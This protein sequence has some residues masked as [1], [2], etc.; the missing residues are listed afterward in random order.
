MGY[1]FFILLTFF[2]LNKLLFYSI[3]RES[4]SLN[5]LSDFLPLLK[6]MFYY[7][8]VFVFSF[9]TLYVAQLLIVEK[10]PAKK[11][12]VLIIRS[13]FIAAAFVYSL[14]HFV[15][16]VFYKYNFELPSNRTVTIMWNNRHF[17]AQYS[18]MY[19][20]YFLL[21]V[22]LV[23]GISYLLFKKRQ[24]VQISAHAPAAAI[25]ALVLGIMA[26]ACLY[27]SKGNG[28]LTPNSSFRFVDS[29]YR[30]LVVNPVFNLAYSYAKGVQP[31]DLFI[32]LLE[33]TVP[34]TETDANCTNTPRPDQFFG[35]YRG[36]NVMIIV[37]ESASAENFD[38][39]SPSKFEMPFFDSLKKHSLYFSNAYA[40]SYVS[41]GG[42]KALYTGISNLIT[43]TRPNHP[44]VLHHARV[45]E[46][47]REQGYATSFYYS[48][49]FKAADYWKIVGFAGVRDYI[50]GSMNTKKPDHS[51]N[52]SDKAFFA[53]AANELKQQPQ[54]FFTGIANTDTHNPFNQFPEY[55]EYRSKSA[56]LSQAASMR[57]FDDVLRDFFHQIESNPW[58]A[59]TL[60]VFVGDH[61]ARAD[62]MLNRSDW[63]LLRIPMMLYDPNRSVIGTAT[64]PVQQIDIPWTLQHL[65]GLK[66]VTSATPHLLDSSVT[67]RHILT[68]KGNELLF[69]GD[70]LFSRYD[71]IQQKITGVWNYRLDPFLRQPRPEKIPETS[72][73]FQK[74]MAEVKR[75]YRC[76]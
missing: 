28:L 21:V 72:R 51:V 23:A 10:R 62:D 75:L 43:D 2:V 31:N 25:L 44:Y 9:W 63:G 38:A 1:R 40:N 71:L 11:I 36:K 64:Y 5:D 34:P 20:G 37:M 56:N 52:V 42:V 55:A 46:L 26:A 60:F 30:D 29:K 48:Q 27:E 70:S 58:F 73:L 8:I 57:Y 66:A 61:Y 16:A 19:A 14:I 17:A 6:G 47:A 7:D 13:L 39:A 12:P 35:R 59:N 18:N 41:I 33:Q 24:K 67:G 69:A 49:H 32:D 68:R 4:F 3:V 74:Q 45:C 76:R 22:G 65:L 15:G 54:P 53:A 50:D